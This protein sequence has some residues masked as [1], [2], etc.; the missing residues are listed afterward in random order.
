MLQISLAWTTEALLMGRKTSTCRDWKDSHAQR[1]RA[2]CIVTAL[3][4]DARWGGKPIAALRLT[5]DA[6]WGDIFDV[7][8]NDAYEAEGFAYFDERVAAGDANAA[9][10]LK[11]NLDIQ[12]GD[13]LLAYLDRY[14]RARLAYPSD[15]LGWGEW[16]IRF[17]L[18]GLAP[19]G[20]ELRAAALERQ[21]AQPQL[22]LI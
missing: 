22:A 16:I 9:R 5:H 11:K 10:L 4:R 1:F 21:A 19:H 18:L 7:L 6:I 13:T 15:A 12:T 3:D 20:D 14:Q 8:G 2:G 17:E